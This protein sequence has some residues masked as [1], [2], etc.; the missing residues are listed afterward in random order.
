MRY[1]QGGRDNLRIIFAGDGHKFVV[2][3][4]SKVA[5]GQ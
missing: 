3:E 5:G 4:G 2:L 1:T